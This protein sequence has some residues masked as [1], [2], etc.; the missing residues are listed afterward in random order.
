MPKAYICQDI[1]SFEPISARNEKEKKII[2]LSSRQRSRHSHNT[3]FI[4]TMYFSLSLTQHTTSRCQSHR[5]QDFFSLFKFFSWEKE[6]LFLD[7]LKMNDEVWGL[8]KKI[9]LCVTSREQVIYSCCNSMQVNKRMTWRSQVWQCRWFNNLYRQKGILLLEAVV[10]LLK[11]G[12]WKILRVRSVSMINA[13]ITAFRKDIFAC[14]CFAAC[15]CLALRN[16]A[17]FLPFAA[18]FGENGRWRER[19]DQLF[20]ATLAVPWLLRT[21]WCLE[22]T[23]SHAIMCTASKLL[24][25]SD[26]LC[27]LLSTAGLL[28]LFNRPRL[29]TQILFLIRSGH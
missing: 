7:E 9:A 1:V 21:K 18:I 12:Y 16:Y 15:C 8:E 28:T 29:G 13:V 20:D 14:C 22:R 4:S 10:F 27:H 25:A 17:L 6:T 3:L 5:C 26:A 23:V 24:I 2:H 19:Q 11:G